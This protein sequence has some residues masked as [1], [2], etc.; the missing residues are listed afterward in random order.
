M[1]NSKD[2]QAGSV[3]KIGRF[4]FSNIQRKSKVSHFPLGHWNMSNKVLFVK[5]FSKFIG[6]CV[7]KTYLVHNRK[8][9]ITQKKKE[10]FDKIKNST[11]YLKPSNRFGGKGIKIGNDPMKLARNSIGS[12]Y[13]VLQQEV[14]NLLLHQDRKFDLRVFVLFVYKRFKPLKM[15]LCKNPIARVSVFKYDEKSF[16]KSVQV[17]NFCYQKN[18][19]NFKKSECIKQLSEISNNKEIFTNLTKCLT[20]LKSTMFEALDKAHKK[21]NGYWLAGLDFIIDQSFKPWFLEVNFNPDMTF[22]NGNLKI[23]KKI[24]DSIAGQVLPYLL[25]PSKSKEKLNVDKSVFV[26]I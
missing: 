22:D 1:H 10:E 6:N 14:P 12:R 5:T 2:W 20:E 19:K 7:P 21:Q 17:T 3:K 24:V 23:C 26:K 15:Y 4:D 13:Y 9:M 8:I 18:N 25:L 16:K 11:F